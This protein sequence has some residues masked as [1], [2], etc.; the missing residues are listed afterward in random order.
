MMLP[1]QPAAALDEPLEDSTMSPRQLP[2]SKETSNPHVIRII[3]AAILACGFF[4]AVTGGIG[5]VFGL[6]N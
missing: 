3:I 6:T 4:D 2:K 1:Q 5:Q